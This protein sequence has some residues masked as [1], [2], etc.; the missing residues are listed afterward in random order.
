MYLIW[1]RLFCLNVDMFKIL[2]LILC[3]IAV[4]WALCMY[5]GE[6]AECVHLWRNC[7]SFWRMHSCSQ[8]RLFNTHFRGGLS[9]YGIL[10]GWVWFPGDTRVAWRD[11][12]E[13]IEDTL[14]E[15]LFSVIPIQH[16]KNQTQLGHITTALPGAFQ[17]TVPPSDTIQLL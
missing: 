10:A 12:R 17:S 3:C 11:P 16:N 9:A 2:M 1:K 8:P 15:M 6:H 5:L 4:L 14:C 13:E 7:V